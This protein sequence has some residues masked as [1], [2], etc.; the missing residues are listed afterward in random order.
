VLRLALAVL[1][2][3]S[4]ACGYLVSQQAT[5]AFSTADIATLPTRAFPPGFLLGTATGAHQIE[6]GN[7]NDWTRFEAEPGSVRTGDVSGPAARSWELVD[8]DI[9]LM[10]RLGANAYRFSIEWSRL[11]PTEGVWDEDAWAHYREQLE[12][13]HAAGIRPMVTLL[14]FTLPLWLADRGGVTAL[15]FP[16][17][18]GQLAAEAAARLGPLVD[19]WCTVNEPNIQ[20]LNGYVEGIWPPGLTA[21]DQAVR[22]FASLLR[23]HAAAAAAIRSLDPTAEIGVTISLS[24]FEPEESWN[25]LDQLAAREAARVFDWAFYDAI[26]AGRITFG[27]PLPGVPSIDEPL[28]GLAGSVD[29]FGANYYGRNSVH[30]SPTAP[31]MVEVTP[32]TGKPDVLGWEVYPQGL[33]A[34]LRTIHTR[35]RLPIYITE[36]GI[37]DEG[38]DR[39]AYLQAHMYAVARALQEGIPVKGYFHW[40]LVDSFEWEAGYSKRFGLYKVESATGERTPGAGVATFQQISRDLGILRE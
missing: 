40:T 36:N 13:L 20:I 7:H 26:M 35:Y 24:R 38:G 6:G 12:Q 29:F 30:F 17:Q 1:V 34:I 9:A 31:H 18:F 3:Y 21:T 32:G 4:A 19:L 11:E 28:P 23:A 25:L 22:A 27:L 37:S 39:D 5:V 2:A 15:D 16:E 8:T 33:L 10:Q 14:H